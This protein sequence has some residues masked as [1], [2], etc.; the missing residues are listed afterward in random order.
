MKHHVLL[1]GLVWPEPNSS[2]AGVRMLQLIN[3]FL[4]K[5]Y[6]VSFACAAARSAYSF[7]LEEIG[8]ACYSIQLND[9]SFDVF[10]KVLAP[11]MVVFDRYII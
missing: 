5:E 2:A 6:I 3:S 1:I 8:V 9:P 11:T 7:P 4:E 10:I